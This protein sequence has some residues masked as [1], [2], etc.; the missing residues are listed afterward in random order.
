VIELRHDG[1]GTPAPLVHVADRVGAVGGT[2]EVTPR[3][4]R[5]ELPCG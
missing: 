2:L 4:V 3:R 1:A 5:A